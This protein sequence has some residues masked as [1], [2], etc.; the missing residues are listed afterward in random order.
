M[1]ITTIYTRHTTKEGKP[2]VQTYRSLDPEGLMK[3]LRGAA[4]ET[5]TSVEQITAEQFLKED[6]S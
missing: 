1:A 5:K 6:R 2:F 4:K 3:L